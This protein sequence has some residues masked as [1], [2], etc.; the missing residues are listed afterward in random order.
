MTIAY[1][2]ELPLV[3][4]IA[5]YSDPDPVVVAENI[6]RA[7]RVG[8]EINMTG[9]AWA[10]VPHQ[11]GRDMEDSLTPMQWYG[12]TRA[13]MRGCA[14]TWAVDFDTEGCAAEI[15]DALARSLPVGIPGLMPVRD[16]LAGL[17]VRP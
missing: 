13:V 7:I 12:M 14:A 11:L 2:P 1:P 5:R 6:Q 17:V 3:Y 4:V 8:A 9:L 16:F 10:V 15:S